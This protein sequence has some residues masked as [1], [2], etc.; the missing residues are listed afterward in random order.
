M[1]VDRQTAAVRTYVN[2]IAAAA[3]RRGQW[4]DV[5]DK[6]H[7]HLQ[8]RLDHLKRQEKVDLLLHQFDRGDGRTI[9]FGFGI[10][11]GRA[12]GQTGVEEGAQL[13]IKL[14][15][16]GFV[17][18]IYASHHFN[19]GSD[20]RPGELIGSEEPSE[21]ATPAKVDHYLTSFL[22]R[23]VNDHWSHVPERA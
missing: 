2:A 16:K 9:Q 18:F 3:K 15:R 6:I 10:Q 5:A 7:A 13:L 11:P 23:A 4:A 17:D 14:S 22:E 20:S 21:A 1:S 12:N 8:S 19:D